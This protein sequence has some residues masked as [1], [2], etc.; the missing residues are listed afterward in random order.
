MKGITM[1]WPVVKLCEAQLQDVNKSDILNDGLYRKCNTYKGGG[2]YDQFPKIYAKRYGLLDNKLK[3]NNQFVVQLQGCP[4]KCPY[5]YVTVEGI[6]GN[7]TLVTTVNLYNA[8]CDSGCDVFHLMGGAPGLYIEHWYEIIELLDKPFHSDLLLVEKEYDKYIIE[9]LAHYKNTLYA[10][11][12]K[13]A[14]EEEFY[15]NT[16]AKL[17][18]QLF[19]NNL[20]VLI[21]YDFPFYLTFTGMSDESIYRFKE[22]ILKRYNSDTILADSF[23]IDLIKYKALDYRQDSN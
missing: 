18:S 1:K 21:T 6:N 14:G 2:G 4:L 17:N 3:L 7:A 15:K 20:D 16:Q 10:V 9:R 12:I 11:S 8:F 19:W 13:G 22:L 5:C 23:K